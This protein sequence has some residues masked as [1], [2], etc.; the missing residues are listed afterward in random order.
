MRGALS[1]PAHLY[2]TLFYQYQR[3]GAASSAVRLLPV[4][5]KYLEVRSV[6]DVG[7]GA[8][9]WIRAYGELGV[10]TCVGI[11]GEYV[12]RSLLLMKPD[13]F[14]P[15]D[16]TSSFDLGRQF[17]IVQCLEVAEHVPPRFSET[18]IDNITRH[19]K[20]VLF[21]AAP[22]G[23][24]GE[25]HINE[26]PYSYWRDGFVRRGF[27]LF[28][29]VR[30]AVRDDPLIEPWYRFNV[31]FFAHDSVVDELPSAVRRFQVPDDGPI[32]DFAPLTYRARKLL[33][34]CLSP[35]LVS[36]MAAWKHRRVVD[37]MKSL[38]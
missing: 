28:D 34:R 6:L 18:L 37:S 22:P 8:G 21:S 1:G 9:A 10:K 4:V 38:N 24:G 17:D 31:L 29:F 7:C 15:L 23:Q 5:L 14:R 27:H 30:P 11:D 25:N 12:D 13:D 3:A 33:L 16:I 35:K 36:R 32:V 19:G 20:A 26:R 2:G